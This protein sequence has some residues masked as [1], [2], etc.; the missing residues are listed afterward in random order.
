MNVKCK[1]V[2]KSKIFQLS[3]NFVVVAYGIED[4]FTVNLHLQYSQALVARV[5]CS[6]A[7]SHVYLAHN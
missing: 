4:V 2:Y 3:K 5:G 1:A 6:E 7:S